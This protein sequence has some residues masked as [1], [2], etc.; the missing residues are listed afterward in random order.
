M[1]TAS[2][3]SATA[4]GPNLVTVLRNTGEEQFTGAGSYPVGGTPVVLVA[5]DV[6]SDGST[7]LVTAN[8]GAN[9]VSVLLG[10]DDGRFQ[11]QSRIRVGRTPTGL[12]INDLDADGTLDLV[13]A[14]RG[15]KTVTV[16]LNSVDAPQPVV[17]LVP[18][19]A[20]RTLAV[21]RRLVGAANCR[22]GLVRRKHSKR[23]RRGR[24][25]SVSPQP[26]DARSGRHRSNA[27]R[28]QGPQ[29]L[30]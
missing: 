4:H 17:C 27:P 13:T 14:N 8:R 20:R 29:A 11:Q 21:A 26:A 30:A 5:A 19:V 22:V 24:V 16:L 2:S 10:A 9:D 28:Q 15:S 6:D 1:P 23:V 12:A 18:T 7:D 3:T 25:I